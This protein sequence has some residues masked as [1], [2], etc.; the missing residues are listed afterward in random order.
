M[1][2]YCCE[3]WSM[4]CNGA[5]RKKC[6]SEVF[7]NMAK[8]AAVKEVRNKVKNVQIIKLLSREEFASGMGQRMNRSC[9]ARM[10]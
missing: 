7:T 1:Q 2:Q 4:C 6:S 10:Q 9:A 3:R 8:Y 5:K